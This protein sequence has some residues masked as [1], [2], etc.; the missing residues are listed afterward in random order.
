L[1]ITFQKA[2]NG[3]ETALAGNFF[4][5]S[6]YAPIKE[7]ER[8]VENLNIPYTPSIII[9][10]EAALSYVTLFLKKKFPTARLGVIRYSSYLRAL[11][12]GA[13]CVIDAASSIFFTNYTTNTIMDKE[14]YFYTC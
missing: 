12:F 3:E 4:L 10:T 6:N 13:S 11:N 14:F 9:I 1:D 2:K 8:F 5:H 7:A